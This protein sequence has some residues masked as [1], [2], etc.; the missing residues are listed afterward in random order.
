M[1]TSQI[2]DNLRTR[3][4]DLTLRNRL[5]NFRYAPKSVVRVIDEVPSIL[6]TKLLSGTEL[7]FS[8]IPEPPVKDYEEEIVEEAPTDVVTDGDAL[9]QDIEKRKVR[10]PVKKHA[11]TLGIDTNFELSPRQS[12][13]LKPTHNDCEIQTLLYPDDLERSMSRVY[14]QYKTAIEETG[15]NLLY[16]TFGSIEYNESDDSSES[17]RSPLVL[18]PVELKRNQPEQGE[19]YYNFSIHASGEEAAVNLTLVEK[20]KR[21]HSINLPSAKFD[22]ED[23]E[24]AQLS[25]DSYF[26]LVNDLLVKAKP[27]WKIVYEVNL[28]ILNFGKLVLYKDLHPENWTGSNTCISEHPLVTSICSGQS[29]DDSREP[30]LFA[31]DFALDELAKDQVPNL[32][33]DADSSQHSA[34]IDVL[35]GK[36]LVIEGPPGTGK[37][38]TITNLIASTLAQGK[39]VLFIAEKLAALEV[40]KKR[41][42]AAGLG[43]FCLELHSTKVQKKAVLDS[44]KRRLEGKYLKPVDIKAN[45]IRFENYKEKINEYVIAILTTVDG[46]SKTY[47]ECVSRFAFLKSE[48]ERSGISTGELLAQTITVTEPFEDAR[49]RSDLEK[50]N[51]YFT[52]VENINGTYG[53][54]GRHPW[55]IA[56]KSQNFSIPAEVRLAKTEEIQLKLN[57]LCDV[58]PAMAVCPNN[59]FSQYSFSNVR[60]LA[61]ICN[62]VAD[63]IDVLAPE[64][65]NVLSSHSHMNLT[66]VTDSIDKVIQS[67]INLKRLGYDHL[68]T[69]KVSSNELEQIQKAV[70]DLPLLRNRKILDCGIILDDLKKTQQDLQTVRERFN[71]ICEKL[72]VPSPVRLEDIFQLNIL[73]EKTLEVFK[74]DQTLIDV[75]I[76]SLNDNAIYDGIKEKAKQAIQARSVF[77]EE[78]SHLAYDVQSSV[79]Q[80]N[81][82]LL[83]KANWFTSLFNSQH[84][85]A[86]TWIKAITIHPDKAKYVLLSKHLNALY[87]FL[88]AREETDKMHQ[89]CELLGPLYKGVDT[90]FSKID[91]VIDTLRTLKAGYFAFNARG[92]GLKEILDSVTAIRD[93]GLLKVSGGMKV[94]SVLDEVSSKVKLHLSNDFATKTVN[95]LSVTISAYISALSN[96]LG[97]SY[98]ARCQDVQI[99][100][101]PSVIAQVFSN[102]ESR[103]LL[104]ASLPPFE[105][106]GFSCD[107]LNLLKVQISALQ[108]YA[109]R[110]NDLQGK[111]LDCPDLLSPAWMTFLK[112]VSEGITSS[113]EVIDEI[114]SILP[115]SALDQSVFSDSIPLDLIEKIEFALAH[116]ELFNEWE[117]ISRSRTAVTNGLFG[118]LLP[119]LEVYQ[120]KPVVACMVAEAIFLRNVIQRH[121]ARNKILSFFDGLAHEDLR[122]RFSAVDRELLTLTRAE[123]ASELGSRYVPSGT[124]SGSR[125]TWTNLA[126]IKRELEKAQRHIPVRQL[127]GR[128]G[129]AIQALKP[130]FMMS[131]LSV[132]QFLPP[133][134]VEFDLIVMDEASQLRPEDAI[135][136]IARG[137]QVV[138][139]GDTKQLP[140]TSFFDV[141]DGV[142]DSDSNVDSF[143]SI[144]EQ[145]AGVFRPARRLKWHYR[146]RHESLIAFSNSQFYES[147]LILFPTSNG[148][149]DEY[150]V[151]LRYVPD[152]IYEGSG[153]NLVEAKSVVDAVKKHCR[154]FPGQSLGIVTMNSAQRELIEELLLN[155][156]KTDPVLAE[157]ISGEEEKKEKFFIKNLENVQGDERDVIFISVTYGRDASGAFHHRFGPINQKNG[158]RRLNVLFSR[159]KNRME[160]FCSFEPEMLA[161][162]ASIGAQAL[163]GF[164]EYAKSG[165][166]PTIATPSGKTYDNPFEIAVARAIEKL[167]FKVVPQVGVAGYFLDIG[168]LDPNSPGRYI[169][170]VE[171]DGATYHSSKCAR[172]R[173]RLRQQ[174][175]ENLGWTIHRVWS[176]DWF[177]NEKR[178]VARLKQKLDSMLSGQRIQPQT[179]NQM[180]SPVAVVLDKESLRRSLIEFREHV[181]KPN[182]PSVPPEMGLLRRSILELVV[183]NTPTSETEFNTLISSKG[184]KFSEHH[185]AYVGSVLEIVDRLTKQAG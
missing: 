54:M 182:T 111:V 102:S 127:I 28:C 118:D 20:L 97:K 17:R 57:L 113:A 27:Q 37:S 149:H 166:L 40:V 145:A 44:I 82:E 181:I 151:K 77:E 121:M 103:D 53:S 5:L 87:C 162:A 8:P 84:K 58:V 174:N 89:H 6:F 24:Q 48:L 51:L 185:R 65:L 31:K 76:C 129:N 72:E 128:A 83:K 22:A 38:Q 88:K 69:L 33:Y 42:D 101:L 47:A 150:G 11:E 71:E 3:L 115:S 170:G 78:F 169:L 74:F 144:L 165:K 175:L 154:T 123:I 99:S 63:I 131:P 4:L 117:N 137:K 36:S 156:S 21:E 15:N 46:F 173:D 67:A 132:A 157:F 50:V 120:L 18:L 152:G 61:E 73:I 16:L 64:H 122:S 184:Y 143:E 114:F 30:S 98:I 142:T 106:S 164:L 75:G 177:K 163:K 124:A 147:E 171:C 91:A 70:G 34:L 32:I 23:E 176:T 134:K 138:V 155:D 59:R 14:N 9:P 45:R 56:S 108:N 139:V 160:V 125:S 161:G 13:N 60:V 126:L 112:Q 153:R 62:A 85:A 146:S 7:S 133:G 66:E 35:R 26:S 100:Q 55:Q 172:D 159:S 148:D 80:Q 68:T 104:A 180:P 49:L 105:K 119:L 1:P 2:L 41:L 25:L 183:T 158:Y 109:N 86:R 79:V 135:G 107:N 92:I 178:E 81:I 130:C 179:V 10:P 140:P 141:A 12:S 43:D 93:S 110:I 94:G 29:E 116:K 167:N 96:I 52:F 168:V 136:A 19:P 95:E 90:N 39:T